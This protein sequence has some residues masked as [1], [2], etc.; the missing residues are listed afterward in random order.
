MMTRIFKRAVTA[1]VLALAVTSFP[2]PVAAQA[3]APEQQDEFRPI[4]ELPPQD[5]LPA[6]PLLIT[7]YSVVLI[8]LFVYILSIARRLGTVQREVERLETDLKRGGPR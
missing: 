6:A 8:A 7:A 2:A 3:P 4:S 1:C 5:Q